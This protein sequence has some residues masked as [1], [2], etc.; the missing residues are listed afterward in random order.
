MSQL[1]NAGATLFNEAEM[2]L[3]YYNNMGGNFVATPHPPN[4]YLY[5]AGGTGYYSPTVVVSTLA[6]FFADPGM[7]PTGVMTSWFQ[8]DMKLAAAMGLKRIAYEGGPDLGS[9]N[10]VAQTEALA[11][12]AINDSR[13]T[14]AIVNMHNAW[15]NNGGDLFV[16]YRSSGDYQ[17]SFTQDVYSLSTQKLLAI[18]AL[19]TADH[20]PITFGTLVPGNIAGNAADACSTNW[21]CSMN[22]FAA[23]G[24]GTNVWASYSFRS[25]ALATWTV[26]LSFASASTASVA[27]YV[28]GNQVD[29]TKTTTGGALG[30]NA[31]SIGAGLHGVIVR[32]VAGSFSIDSVAVALN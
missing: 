6:E 8:D 16:Y 1:T 15:S 28:D 10:Y 14:T 21:G 17:W 4:Y 23:S 11:T 27:V 19:N 26:N 30:F 7:T 20:A 9:G 25:S 32:A 2:M 5:G 31:G 29:V 13:M 18:D 3:N 22:S 24:T 12:Q